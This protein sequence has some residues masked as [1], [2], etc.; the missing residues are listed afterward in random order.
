MQLVILADQHIRLETSGG[1]HGLT[2]EG[3]NF[4]ALQMLATSLALCTASVI[5]AYAERA[6]LDVY[7]FAVELRWEYA[8][9]PYRV[10]RYEMTLHLPEHLPAAR[11]RA[12]QRAAETCTVHHTLLHPPMIETTVQTFAETHSGTEHD[13]SEPHEHGPA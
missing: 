5:Q 12:I 11:Q 10:G 8:E 6:H 1:G 9:K 13:H 3:D 7:G 2:V 4:G